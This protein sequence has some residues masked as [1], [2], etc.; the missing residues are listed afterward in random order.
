MPVVGSYV[1]PLRQHVSG[2]D[3]GPPCIC[4]K[5]SPRPDSEPRY[6]RLLASDGEIHPATSPGGTFQVGLVDGGCAVVCNSSF[7]LESQSTAADGIKHG[8]CWTCGG[9]FNWNECERS[10]CYH[11][12]SNRCSLC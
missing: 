1:T 3:A 5:P 8:R 6:L 4:I 9:W 11:G 2:S 12:S 7:D 10:S